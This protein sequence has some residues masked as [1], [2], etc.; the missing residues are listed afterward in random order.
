MNLIEFY[1]TPR[2]NVQYI[3]FYEN[4]SRDSKSNVYVNAYSDCP[5]KESLK[6]YSN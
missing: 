2:M 5:R 6:M 1:Y 3:E 4:L